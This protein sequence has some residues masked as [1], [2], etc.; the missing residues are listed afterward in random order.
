M[1]SRWQAVARRLPLRSIDVDY[2]WFDFGGKRTDRCGEDVDEFSTKAPQLFLEP[3]R[4]RELNHGQQFIWRFGA[5][6]LGANFEWIFLPIDVIVVREW[7]QYFAFIDEVC[8]FNRWLVSERVSMGHATSFMRDTRSIEPRYRQR[9]QSVVVPLCHK[10]GACDT[11]LCTDATRFR[12]RC[13]WPH[14]LTQVG[15]RAVSL[16]EVMRNFVNEVIL[17][18]HRPAD[19]KID[20]AV[21]YFCTNPTNSF[22]CASN[23]IE[24]G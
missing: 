9:A 6:T 12:R 1:V 10:W 21:D 22:I 24:E 15:F 18:N 3:W 13:H 17:S 5:C 7:V 16:I 20:A 4:A 19:D 23:F 11:G 2:H 14:R 8:P